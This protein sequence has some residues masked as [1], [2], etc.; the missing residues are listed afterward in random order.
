MRD[1]LILLC[2]FM[3][4]YLIVESDKSG[5]DS[6]TMDFIRWVFNESDE[7]KSTWSED[8]KRQRDIEAARQNKSSAN[9]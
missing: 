2:F 8:I 9:R 5:K 7:H 4:S 3:A 1:F 6:F